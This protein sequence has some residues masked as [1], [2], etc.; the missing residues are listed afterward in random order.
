LRAEEEIKRIIKSL[1]GHL[2]DKD[3]QEYLGIEI[4]LDKYLNE[5]KEGAK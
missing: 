4:D 5:P 3:I 2:V 1:R